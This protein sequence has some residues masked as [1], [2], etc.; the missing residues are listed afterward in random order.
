[1][2]GLEEVK[3]TPCRP[4]RTIVGSP[5]KKFQEPELPQR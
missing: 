5:W 3:L 1:M 2:D 4:V